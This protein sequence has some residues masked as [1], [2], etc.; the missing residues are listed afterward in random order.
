MSFSQ[1]HAFKGK[2]IYIFGTTK[3]NLKLKVKYFDSSI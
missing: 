1:I 2:Q 3:T